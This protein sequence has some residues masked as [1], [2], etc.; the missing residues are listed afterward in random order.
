MWPRER[1]MPMA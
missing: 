1:A